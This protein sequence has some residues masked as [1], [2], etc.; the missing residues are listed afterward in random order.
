MTCNIFFV[1]G[2][3]LKAYLVLTNV[4]ENVMF[5]FRVDSTLLL[6]YKAFETQ[7]VDYSV[8]SNTVW[9]F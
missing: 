8:T 9:L 5:P 7:D 2:K 1:F 4:F 6:E 3:Q